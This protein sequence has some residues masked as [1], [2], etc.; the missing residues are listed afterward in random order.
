MSEMDKPPRR[1][2]RRAWLLGGGAVAGAGVVAYALRDAIASYIFTRY[3]NSAFRPSGIAVEDSAMCTLTASA[4]EGPFYVE[5]TPL[6]SDVREDRVGVPVQLNLRIVDGATCQA[7]SGAKVVIWQADALGNYSGHDDMDPSAFPFAAPYWEQRAVATPTRYLRGYQVTGAD[8]IVA[9]RTIYPGW[10]TPRTPHIHVK[11]IV[12]DRDVVSVQLFFPQSVTDEIAKV[13]PYNS[14]GPSP[15]T[16]DNDFVI[17]E[18]KGASGTWPKISRSGER[19]E[20]S[21]TIGIKGLS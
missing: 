9:F 20:A 15:Y 13:T 11:A 10:Y 14:R 6:R 19:I 4:I 3:D 21:L 18:T 2:S 5:N 17:A 7:I 12:A 1:L 8:G 16:N